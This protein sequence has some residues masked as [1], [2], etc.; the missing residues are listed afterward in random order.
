[1]SHTPAMFHG[2]AGARTAVSFFING[3][4][5]H[6]DASNPSFET[7]IDELRSENADPE[8]LIALTKPAQIIVQAV[9]DAEAADYLAAG[10]V[11]VTTSEVRYNG[12]MVTG[13]LVK[14]ILEML[15]EGFNIMPM[16]RFLENLYLNPNEWARDELYLWLENN[17]LPITEDGCFLAY[18]KVNVNF[19]SIH[20]GKTKNDPGRTVS[21]PRH[22]VDT[23]RENTCSTG[24]HFCSKS[25]L[26]K[27]G[28]STVIVLKIN[29]ADVVSIPSDYDNAKGRAWKYEVLNVFGEDPATKVWP[30]VVAPNGETV[31][32]PTD[33]GD[34]PLVIGSDLAKSLFAAC[35]AI[36]LTDR[37]DRLE[38]AYE[39]LADR[40]DLD[41]Y[42]VV[43][44]FVYLTQEQATYLLAEADMLRDY[45]EAFKALKVE[46][47][48][49]SK[50]AQIDAINS[51][52]IIALR[53]EASK[54]GYIGAWKGPNA[55]ALRAYLIRNIK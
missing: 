15:S 45:A 31:T 34:Q 16:V 23:V 42:F 5:Y 38:W 24:L 47:K 28:G 53:R 37:E 6:A 2:P 41:D 33:N 48:E 3:V 49:D 54:A 30:T 55:Y 36:G 11:S 18:K 51:Y 10:V 17:N 29:P 13:V 25:Y 46:V 4:P 12:D 21:V 52:G 8:R 22:T 26:P 40:G 44:S 1:M 27:F 43:D 39:T 9:A 7:L 35:N 32:L 14:R 19:T 20:D 50:Q